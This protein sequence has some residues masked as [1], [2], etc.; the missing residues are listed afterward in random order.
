MTFLAVGGSQERIAMM[1]FW[2]MGQNTLDISRMLRRSE[3][4]VES[5][6]HRALEIRRHVRGSLTPP[7][8]D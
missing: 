3:E 6:L 8:L 7:N 4:Y 5:E 1:R 2:D